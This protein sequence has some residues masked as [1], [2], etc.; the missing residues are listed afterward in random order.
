MRVFIPEDEDNFNF[1]DGTWIYLLRF[2]IERFFSVLKKRL[3]FG[4]FSSP[5]VSSQEAFSTMSALA[6]LQ[7]FFTKETGSYTYSVKPWHR[8]PKSNPKGAVSSPSHVQKGYSQILKKIGTPSKYRPPRNIPDGRK[9]GTI[10]NKREHCPVIKK[11]KIDTKISSKK[12]SF[13]TSMESEIKNE[14]L[15]IGATVINEDIKNRQENVCITNVLLIIICIN[16]F[17]YFWYNLFINTA[18]AIPCK[19]LLLEKSISIPFENTLQTSNANEI[20]KI[21][22]THIKILFLKYDH[23]PPTK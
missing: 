14:A 4:K 19:H 21:R 15:K 9:I 12:K 10:L 23:D 22:S 6:Y 18:L 3:F 1:A 16:Y 7:W 11:S 20:D 8:Y 5:E 2:Q 17:F 13:A